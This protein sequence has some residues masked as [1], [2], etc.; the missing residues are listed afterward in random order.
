MGSLSDATD[1]PGP[2]GSLLLTGG[3]PGRWPARYGS[4]TGSQP[5]SAVRMSRLKWTVARSAALPR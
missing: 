1:E 5:P 2:I 4:R 3:T